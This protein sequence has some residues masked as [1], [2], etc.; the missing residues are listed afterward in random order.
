MYHSIFILSFVDKHFLAYFHTLA[1]VDNIALN[2]GVH[3]FFF[4]IL[5]L[6]CSGYILKNRI[7]GSYS[8]IFVSC[9]FVCLFVFLEKPPYCFP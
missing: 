7:A 6:F 5:F 2:I 1:I 3:E 4:E 9:L 8:S